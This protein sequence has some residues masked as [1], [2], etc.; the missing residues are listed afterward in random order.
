MLRLRHP[1]PAR[2]S[3]GQRGCFRSPQCTRTG[4]PQAGPLA[5]GAT[6]TFTASHDTGPEHASRPARRGPVRGTATA[7]PRPGR[8]PSIV[9]TPS[10]TERTRACAATRGPDDLRPQPRRR[11][12]ATSG[13]GTP[14]S[15]PTAA[16][17]SLQ[18]HR[19]VAVVSRASRCVLVMR[20]SSTRKRRSGATPS[21]S[22]PAVV[23]S[24]WPAGRLRTSA[25][26]RA[27]VELAEHVVEQ[28]HRRACR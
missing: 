8:R 21:G 16:S 5:G 17:A 14:S 25:A 9:H 22:A 2:E 13:A 1:V 4:R 23:S 19:L 15:R 10:R 7:S 18:R 12:R 27:R 24:V 6:T 20:P 28:Q 11:A 26:A 3:P